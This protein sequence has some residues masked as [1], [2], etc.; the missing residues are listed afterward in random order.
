MPI[1][2]HVAR[3]LTHHRRPPSLFWHAWLSHPLLH[4]CQ[5]CGLSL[6]P[7]ALRLLQHRVS[8][9]LVVADTTA[10]T[11]ATMQFIGTGFNLASL[12]QQATIPSTGAGRSPTSPFSPSAP[13][14]C[15]DPAPRAN[16][17]HFLPLYKQ[18][19]I[20]SARNGPHEVPRWPAERQTGR[21]ARRQ[22]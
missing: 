9:A 4:Y 20:T 12:A 13:P 10:T 19:T 7:A 1:H 15:S 22:C 8:P 5:V 14:S 21:I 6:L 16:R 3:C 18:F 17:Y 2:R 11:T